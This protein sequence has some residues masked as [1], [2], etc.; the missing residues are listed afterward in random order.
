[1]KIFKVILYVFTS[2]LFLVVL[3]F[4]LG[5]ILCKYIDLPETSFIQI[6]GYLSF[7]WI[8]VISAPV[9][10]L[11]LLLPKKRKALSFLL[12]M[13]LFTVLLNDISLKSFTR[14]IPENLLSY[15]SLKVAAYNVKY[16]GYGI[17]NILKYINESDIDVALLSESQLS[18]EKLDWLKN[19]VKGYSVFSDGGHDLSILSKYPVVNYKVVELPTYLASLSGSN[20][21]DRLKES[22]IHRSFIHAIVDVNGSLVNILSL[23][24]I[25]GR[26]KDK[27]ISEAIR[28][29]KYL[30]SAQNEELDSFLSYLN[31]L[32][33]CVIFGGDLNCPPNSRIIHEI[34]KHVLDSYSE[35][36]FMGSYTFKAS[37][38]TAR[39]DFI[40]HSKDIRVKRSEIVRPSLT[41]HPHLSD[42]FMIKTEFL[43]GK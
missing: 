9:F 20:D 37:M 41:G 25:A 23:R 28:W 21:I 3:I 38:P 17:E 11:L 14:N 7:Y 40:F 4:S 10:L 8:L 35:K 43:I 31:S 2:F 24:L 27:T 12:L 18:S 30:M 39:L 13:I 16:Y 22:G 15:D 33:G 19:N 34:R 1:M 42:H 6:F 32:K 29:G 36:H 5:S 26:P